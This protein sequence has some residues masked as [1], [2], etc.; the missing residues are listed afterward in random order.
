MVALDAP[1]CAHCGKPI[2]ADARFCPYC[3]ADLSVAPQPPAQER[4]RT[5]A[6]IALWTGGVLALFAV[7]FAG[8]YYFQ[9][10]QREQQR[11]AAARA[12]PLKF[13]QV[14]LALS[15]RTGEALAPPATSFKDTEIANNKYLKWSA[16]FD[17][18]LAG[19]G[20]GTRRSRCAF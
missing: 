14:T 4:T 7:A 18:E 20:G 2:P 6:R 15:T 5:A 17:N 3:S 12:H 11:I 13:D 16:T 1:L 8:A 9:Q 10:Y 19:I